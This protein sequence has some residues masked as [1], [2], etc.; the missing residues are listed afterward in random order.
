MGMTRRT[1]IGAGAAAAAAASA[2]GAPRQARDYHLCVSQDAIADDPEL[3]DLVREA[4]VTDFWFAAFLEGQWPFPLERTLRL[5][6]RLAT[7][8]LRTHLIN[9]PLGHPRDVAAGPGGEPPMVGAGPW[10]PGM[11]ADGRWYGGNA[12]HPPVVADNVAAIRRLREAGAGSV[13]LDDD[14]RLAP[15]PGMIGGCFCEDHRRAFLQS[16]GY[17][18][19]RWPD[20]IAAVG[21]RSLTPLLREWIA[22]TCDEL[23]ACFRAQQHA[24]PRMR[25]GNMVMFMGAEKAGIR[26][27]DY[28][29]VPFR[30]GE[31]M[32]DD[33][34][35]G[36]VKGKTDEL[37]SSLFH[38]RFTTPDLAFSE[39]TAYP[40]DRLSAPNMAAKLAIST[41]SDVRH[42]MMM[43]GL[44]PFPKAHWSVLGS[45]MRRNA[46][47]HAKIA[48]HRPRGPFKHLWGERGRFVSDD[49]AFSLFLAAGVPFEVTAEP[50]ASGWTFLGDH[51]AAAVAERALRSRGT[52]FVHR[53]SVGRGVEGGRA[54][55]ETLP[56]LFRLK[57]E[58]RPHLGG[59]PVVEQDVPVVC[60]WYPT[61]RAAVLWNLAERRERVTVVLS[62]DR[63]EVDLGPLDI[64]LVEN[65][66]S[67]GES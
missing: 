36:R 6:D 53:P 3:L 44:T 46:A 1:F 18:A 29:G 39:T 41:L 8:G 59:V 11:R 7:M 47:I 20:L 57:R 31:L 25:L 63:R 14:F 13:F 17:P 19:E 22:F 60:A 67:R 66:T 15:S 34:S 49:N 4:G 50:A 43:S 26:L 24:A 27:P 61:A 21:K 16:R 54:V 35:F 55:P 30:V 37:F 2:S 48:G 51:D 56:D 45:A 64:A 33:T 38:R 5:R 32:F 12:I 9:L 58:L 62:G 23:T 28:R 10:R 65:L 52:V 40:A 42:T